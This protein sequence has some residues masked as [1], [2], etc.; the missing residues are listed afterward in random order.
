MILTWHTMLFSFL[1]IKIK[2]A[3]TALGTK[4]KS[5]EQ[6][7]HEIRMITDGIGVSAHVSTSPTDLSTVYEVNIKNINSIIRYTIGYFNTNK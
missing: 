4:S 3:L 1:K 6:L 7:E 5:L 2:K